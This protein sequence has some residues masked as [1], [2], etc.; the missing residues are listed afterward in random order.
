MPTVVRPTRRNGAAKARPAPAPK[1][2]RTQPKP[3]QR[4]G[5]EQPA[6]WAE[7][8]GKAPPAQ[9]RRERAPGFV[10]AVPTLRFATLLAIACAVL[11][12]YVGHLY[13]SQSL[14]DEVQQLRQEKLR[15]TLQQNRLRGE[16]DRMTAPAVI[17]HRAEAIGLR[18]SGEYAPTIVVVD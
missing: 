12:L 18:A 17:L 15:L 6:S 3:A 8:A 1:A 13:A 7:L 14:V 2:R 11:T 4:R 9:R 5:P 10:D 16:F